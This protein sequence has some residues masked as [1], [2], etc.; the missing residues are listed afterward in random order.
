MLLLGACT[1]GDIPEGASSASSEVGESLYSDISDRPVVLREP[2]GGKEYFSGFE[3]SLSSESSYFPVGVWMESIAEPAD[4]EMDAAIGLNIYVGLTENSNHALLADTDAQL[5]AGRAVPGRD[6]ALLADEVDMWGGPGNAEWT[7]NWPGMGDIC[8]PASAKCGFD[9]QRKLAQSVPSKML[10]YS[11]YGKGVTFWE[12]DQ[13]ASRFVNKFQDIVSADNYWFTDANICGESEGG[14]LLDEPSELSESECRRASNYGW[15]VERLRGLMDPVGS[16]PVWAFVEVGHPASEPEAPTITG[17]QIR[18]SVWSSLIHGARGI[19]YFNHSFEGEC[20][21]QHVLRDCGTELRDDVGAIN[22]EIAQLSEVLN[23]DFLDGALK[24]GGAVEATT[25]FHE[26]DLYVF[27]GASGDGATEGD[28]RLKCAPDGLV[29]VL[30][31]GRSIS[32]EN[33][34]FKDHF[35]NSNSVHL[36]RI[37]GN[38]CGLK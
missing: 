11:N 26:E 8:S 14:T 27:A 18:A 36:Y 4:L 7:G 34:H 15:T 24:V 13:E 23:A 38:S 1:G 17:A 20:P 10:R 30:N 16:I 32:V 33:G 35:R 9:V 37:P 28:F 2:D 21:S 12:T 5:L 29:E 22:E 31:E 6:G 25:K 19:I 3:P